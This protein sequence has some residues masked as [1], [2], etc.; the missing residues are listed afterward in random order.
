MLTELTPF[1]IIRKRDGRLTKFDKSKITQAI[2]LAFNNSG[3]GNRKHCQELADKVVEDLTQTIKGT[4]PQV[5]EIQDAVE[6]VLI[7]EGNVETAKSYI[8]YRAKRTSIRDGKSDLM[9]A[10]QEILKES[11]EETSFHR[12]SPSAKILDVGRSA[13]ENF[14]LSR[15]I[16]S[17]FSEAHRKGDFHIHDLGYYA[18][19]VHSLQIPLLRLIE[20]GFSSGYGFMRT[21]K[22][23]TSLLAQAAII[24]QACQND[25]TGG[26][27]FPA[28][29]SMLAE[30]AEK[31]GFTDSIES[32]Q[33]AV[34][35]FVYNLNSMY[36][37]VGA[38][39]PLSTVSVGLDTGKWG[40]AV[41]EALLVAMQRGLGRGETPLFPKLVFNVKSG[42]NAGPSD[43]NH[44][45]FRKALEVCRSRMNP[46]FALLDASF[47]AQCAEVAYWAG[48]GRLAESRVGPGAQA[49]RGVLAMLTLNLPRVALKISHRRKSFPLSSFYQ[50][51]DR[52][53][54][55]GLACLLHRFEI[56]SRLRAKEMPFV[57]GQKVY[58]GSEC[59]TGDDPVLA[60]L[61]NGNL[62]LSF[63]GLAEALLVLK[64]KHHG[65][66]G[67]A[68]ALGLEI[69]EF[70]R[71]KVDEFSQKHN[72]NLVLTSA[73]A[74][75][76][77]GKFV[78]L[79]REEFKGAEITARQYYTNGFHVPAAW[80]C[81]PEEII[82]IEAPY[83]AF[84][85]GGHFTFL[86]FPAA[87]SADEME[88]YL[89]TMAGKDMGYGGF[90][91]PIDECVQCGNKEIEEGSC[92]RCSSR[93]IRK[94]RRG[95][96][97][98][99]PMDMHSEGKRTEITDRDS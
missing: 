11:A 5:E 7:K 23:F 98:V 38:H 65:E 19:A 37:R 25:M 78:A 79:D 14:Y 91:F 28:F 99:F 94:L 3:G 57:M 12:I 62:A 83:H 76:L 1:P 20:Q 40:R 54:S 27:S 82:E 18:K 95:S 22:R 88:G 30:F 70:M 59:L 45:L 36:S 55:L 26:Q 64:K 66:D 89:A 50:E 81:T 80:R 71:S 96:A 68:R 73:P 47:N 42:V 67:D 9:G 53:V 56:E 31:Y 60:A 10:V 24:L 44:D 49:G 13:S 35:G 16:P 43:P 52:Q 90:T 17:Q 33:Q 39:V 86:H 72:L 69:V 6:R 87:P 2:W 61:R 21:P 15:V 4:V 8:L 85:N 29:D 93:D 92:I 51:L 32:L 77:A 63:I 48:G 46:T 74:E 58:M 41:T 75:N 34:E 97:Y 84:L